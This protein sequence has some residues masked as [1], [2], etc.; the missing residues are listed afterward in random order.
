MA[1]GKVFILDMKERTVRG[2]WK[3]PEHREIDVEVD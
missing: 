2:V 3:G 1:K